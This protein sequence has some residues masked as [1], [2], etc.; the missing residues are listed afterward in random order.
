MKK[1]RR[2]L[3]E[4]LMKKGKIAIFFSLSF[5]CFVVFEGTPNIAIRFL[6][7]FNALF[8]IE[9]Q[10]LVLMR[11]NHKKTVLVR[12]HTLQNQLLFM[13]SNQIMYYYF[14]NIF[15]IS[16]CNQLLRKVEWALISE[17]AIRNRSLK[18]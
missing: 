12:Q 11:T 1:T 14:Y 10:V 15:A 4:I 9:M 3:K 2:K 5:F 17:S 16:L 7:L 8:L 18:K 6:I 13:I